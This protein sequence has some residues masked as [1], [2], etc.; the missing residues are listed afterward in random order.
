MAVHVLTDHI[1]DTVPILPDELDNRADIG[2][3]IKTATRKPP[4]G[5]YQIHPWRDIHIT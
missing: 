4:S 1:H 3:Q 2:T 5:S